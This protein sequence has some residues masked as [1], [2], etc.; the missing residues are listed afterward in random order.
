MERSLQCGLWTSST[1]NIWELAKIFGPATSDSVS[2]LGNS[3]ALQSLKL[4][5]A[6]KAYLPDF[7]S[8]VSSSL[9]ISLQ[10]DKMQG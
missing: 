10:S 5:A 6:L 4:T 3:D 9:G 2:P 1:G 8:P 7:E